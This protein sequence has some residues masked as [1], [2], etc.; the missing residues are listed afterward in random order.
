METETIEKNEE[1]KNRWE[2][3]DEYSF[4][5][6]PAIDEKFDMPPG[7]NRVLGLIK[8]RVE[9]N[10]ELH[11]LW[12]C[13]NIVAMNRL[14]YSDHGQ[15][16]MEIVAN[17]ALKLLRLLGEEGV[18]PSCMRDYGLTYND[19]EVVLFLAACL[20]DIGHAVHRDCHAEH[21]ICLAAPLLR[22]ILAGTYPRE[23]ATIITAEVL[24]CISAHH[25][26]AKPL[27]V[28]AGILRVSDALDMAHGRTRLWDDESL[29]SKIHAVS[30]KAI[31]SVEVGKGAVKPVQITIRMSGSA[32]VFQVDELLRP[33]LTGS[34]IEN[35]VRIEARV[36]CERQIISDF[37]L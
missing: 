5:E 31:E 12:R 6:A 24:H 33:K 16:H 11:A 7:D 3:V 30:A 20:H 27:T 26:P 2:F 25:P 14:G 36:E 10:E 37:I 34:G 23:Q 32:G 9:R 22:Q 17:H 18:Q 28:E 15:K 8:A 35:Y 1:R 13:S 19:A 4:A 29:N 21:S